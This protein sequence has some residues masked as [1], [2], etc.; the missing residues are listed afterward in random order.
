[1]LGILIYEAVMGAS[2]Y[3][4]EPGVDE[5]VD[6]VID[7]EFDALG[8]CAV[9]KQ[10]YSPELQEFVKRCLNRNSTTRP[11]VAE[12]IDDPLFEVFKSGLASLEDP[13]AQHLPV[14]S[15]DAIGTEDHGPLCLNMLAEGGLTRAPAVHVSKKVWKA[16]AK[17]N[18]KLLKK[19]HRCICIK[20]R[21]PLDERPGK[22]AK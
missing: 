14:D 15:V 13:N 9:T 21:E 16:K 11:S 3:G 4:N 8:E 12:L 2:A 1:A 20:L 19:N 7:V 17:F 10:P 5:L 22:K 6:G 18:S